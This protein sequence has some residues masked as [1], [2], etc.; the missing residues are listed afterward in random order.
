[1]NCD[2]CVH[3]ASYTE[4]SEMIESEVI[5]D[6]VPV[7]WDEVSHE[8]W[9][10]G[11][12]PAVSGMGLT[13]QAPIITSGFLVSVFDEECAWMAAQPAVLEYAKKFSEIHNGILP[14]LGHLHSLF[15]MNRH[16]IP[17]ELDETMTPQYVYLPVSC[18]ACDCPLHEVPYAIVTS[19][20]TPRNP[21]P[22]PVTVYHPMTY[23]DGIDIDM[24]DPRNDELVEALGINTNNEETNPEAE[25]PI[26]R[27]L[28]PGCVRLLKELIRHAVEW[29]T[30]DACT[31]RSQ[32]RLLQAFNRS[33]AQ[34]SSRTVHPM[35]VGRKTHAT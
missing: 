6:C 19:I 3:A 14:A 34:S 33:S 17:E 18:C 1:M 10:T 28:Q 35:E 16:A 12:N 31:T 27:Q 21:P 5:A 22:H 8:P 7:S 13:R 24:N 11:D 23:Y 20:P 26:L 29:Q 4:E 2:E 15:N 32:E 9:P 30:I 25:R